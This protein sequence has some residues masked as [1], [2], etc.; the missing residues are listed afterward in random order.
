[1]FRLQG[2]FA[3]FLLL[4]I[5][6]TFAHLCTPTTEGIS[7]V[8]T[9]YPI[10]LGQNTVSIVGFEASVSYVYLPAGTLHCLRILC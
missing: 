3:A 10:D 5:Q 4:N 9:E 7:A 6:E 1:M 2:L 8:G